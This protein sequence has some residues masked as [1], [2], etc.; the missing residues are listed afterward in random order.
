MTDQKKQYRGIR[1]SATG[2]FGYSIRE[3]ETQ[4]FDINCPVLPHPDIQLAGFHRT[5][6]QRDYDAQLTLGPGVRRVISNRFGRADGYYEYTGPDT[7]DLVSKRGRA[8]VKAKKDGWLVFWKG[9]TAAEI[10]LLAKGQ[11]RRFEENGLDMEE[12]FLVNIE[13]KIPSA[14][15]PYI[16]AIPVLRF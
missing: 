2:I 14:L 15:L 10:L 3:G 13:T 7:F 1:Y 9:A 8:H 4:R 12:R 16:L 5:L 11:G 6:W